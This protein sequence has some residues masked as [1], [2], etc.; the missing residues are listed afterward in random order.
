MNKFSLIQD[1]PSYIDVL[2]LYNEEAEEA[3]EEYKDNK[4]KELSRK[5]R[6]IFRGRS[7]F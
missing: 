1:N 7:G 4:V 2:F 6:E 5:E 3:Y